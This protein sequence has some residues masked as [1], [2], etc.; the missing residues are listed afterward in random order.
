MP[1]RQQFA[2]NTQNLAS[3]YDARMQKLGQ[4]DDGFEFPEISDYVPSDAEKEQMR[5]LAAIQKDAN[6]TRFDNRVR[7]C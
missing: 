7:F 3:K 5:Q 4:I 6:K 1:N 2:A